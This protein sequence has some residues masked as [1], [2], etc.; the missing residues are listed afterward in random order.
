MPSF[1]FQPGRVFKVL[2]AVD[3]ADYLKSTGF[4]RTRRISE[5]GKPLEYYLFCWYLV[6]EN[7]ADYCFCS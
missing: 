4:E 1:E 7:D 3:E 2:F 6:L 5:D